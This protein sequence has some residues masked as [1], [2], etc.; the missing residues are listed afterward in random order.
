MNIDKSTGIEIY[1]VAEDEIAH[2]DIDIYDN[3][4]DVLEHLAMLTPEMDFTTKIYN[5]VLM[6]AKVLPSSTFG[7][8][9]YIVT[10]TLSNDMGSLQLEGSIIESDCADQIE[11]LAEEV[12]ELINKKDAIKF[13]VDIDNV[14]ILYGHELETCL[15]I[16]QESIDDEVI[17]TCKKVAKEIRELE[18][19]VGG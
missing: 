14:F 8:K 19:A 7:K 11:V 3:Y 13:T 4:V 18:L 17:D 15:S 12:E 1:L 9:C 10:L 16:N 6:P 5:G 2:S